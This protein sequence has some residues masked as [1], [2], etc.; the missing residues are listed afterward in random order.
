[1]GNK[2]KAQLESFNCGLEPNLDSFDQ[3]YADSD[4]FQIYSDGLVGYYSLSQGRIMYPIYQEVARPQ[5]FGMPYVAD[6][7]LIPVRYEKYWGLCK[8]ER[9]DGEQVTEQTTE[10]FPCS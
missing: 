4:M 2:L 8:F 3:R 7:W 9:Q 5:N 1:M 10:I 6:F